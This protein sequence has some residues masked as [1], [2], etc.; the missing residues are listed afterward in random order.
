MLNRFHRLA[1]LLCLA[2]VSFWAVPVSAHDPFEITSDAHIDADGLNVRTTLSLTTAART[3]LSGPDRERRLVAAD[4]EPL[5]PAFERC[6]RAYYSI[7]AAGQ[8]LALRSLSL[9]LGVEDDLEIRLIDARPTRTPLVFDAQGLKGL[10]ARAGI[11]L[12]VTGRHTFLGQKVLR[13]D[14]ARF[15]LPITEDAEAIGTPLLP[16]FG[17]FLRLGVEHISS[18]ADHL[19]F[20]LGLLVV[21]RRVKTV[22]IIVSCFS[23]AHSITLALS[24]FEILTLSSRWVEPLIAATIVLVG[25]ENLW[26]G[27][28]PE[29]RWWSRWLA[30]F[31]FGLVHGLGFAGALRGRGLGSFGTSVWQPLLAFNL[32]VELG[33]M[34]IACVLL[35][36]LRQ[37]ARVATLKHLP[38][39]V[40]ILVTLVGAFWLVQRL[41]T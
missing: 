23:L 28:E 12:T 24:T 26:L 4:F 18:G 19:L 25:L 30:T 22:A 34:A 3:C 2:L 14:D 6:A 13:P 1:I 8:P 37:L 17:R 35:V 20:L 40:S 29:G 15:E 36:L 33:Q 31:A 38:Q 39:A 5:R 10:P 11:V 7:T 16:T 9:Q 21:C 41:T 27:Q 32:G